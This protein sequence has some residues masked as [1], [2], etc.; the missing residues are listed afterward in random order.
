MRTLFKCIFHNNKRKGLGFRV[1]SV[2]A[3]DGNSL[4]YEHVADS[5]NFKENNM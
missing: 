4:V 1:F 3:G 2:N 5:K